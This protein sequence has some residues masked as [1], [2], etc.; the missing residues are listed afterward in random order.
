MFDNSGAYGP[1]EGMSLFLTRDLPA[2]VIV[3]EKEEWMVRDH[4]SVVS[5]NAPK[6]K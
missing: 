2:V 5:L 1:T 3:N 4:T 6:L